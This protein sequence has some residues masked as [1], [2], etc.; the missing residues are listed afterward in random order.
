MELPSL[1]LNN[2]V[3][4]GKSIWGNLDRRCGPKWRRLAF[5]NGVSVING[6]RMLT[7]I[8]R[9]W[10]FGGRTVLC[11]TVVIWT[12]CYWQI[13]AACRQRDVVFAERYR[14]TIA[15]CCKLL[16]RRTTALWEKK[17]TIE[18]W[19]SDCCFTHATAAV[20]QVAGLTGVKL[21]TVD[22][23]VVNRTYA[24]ASVDASSIQTRFMH[25][26]NSC[27]AVGLCPSQLNL[28]PLPD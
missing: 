28:K 10:P 25:P 19:D 11:W 23:N 22:V 5:S 12:S 20:R 14:T 27:T 6:G 17:T 3:V 18:R 1:T 8:S 4:D 24:H 15:S 2:L 9:R 16:L 21:Q 7:P 13:D 26:R